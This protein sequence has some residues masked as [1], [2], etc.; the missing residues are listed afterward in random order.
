MEENTKKAIFSPITIAITI[1]TFLAGCCTYPLLKT[2]IPI[3]WDIQ[4]NVSRTAPKEA[5]FLISAIPFLIYLIL[6][7]TNQKRERRYEKGLQ[8][9]S[10]I[11]TYLFVALQW[12]S[13]AIA[14][15]APINVQLVIPIF[16]GI[17]LLI[18]G[19]FMPTVPRNRYC[20]FRTPWTVRSENAWRKANRFG[21]YLL[22]L[23]GLLLIINGVIQKAIVYY[24]IVTILVGGILFGVI[25]SYQL[26][27]K[28]SMEK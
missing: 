16:I 14:M 9:T 21:G 25:L 11:V 12:I 1:A 23:I 10:Y 8:I 5:I 26:W 4:W 22:S 15:L 19:N 28:E 3:Q 7:I 2:D 6:V 27:K 20:G 24:V 13:I 17:C 18:I